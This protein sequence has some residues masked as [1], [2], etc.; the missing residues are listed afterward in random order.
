MLAVKQ[1]FA[2]C[3]KLK[4]MIKVLSVWLFSLGGTA[5]V[6][7]SSTTPPPTQPFESITWPATRATEPTK[8]VTLGDFRVEFESTKL[9]DIRQKA[10]RGAISH[11]GDAAGTVN[12]LCYTVR[13][14]AMSDR[15]WITSSE[16]GGPEGF[17]TGV[18][19]TR[20][21]TLIAVPSC[22]LLPEYLEPISI[23]VPVWLGA[24]A[25]DFDKALGPPSHVE[26]AWRWYNF[27]TK[28]AGDGHCPDGY[29][30]LNWLLTRSQEGRVIAIYA[31]QVTSC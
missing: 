23:D 24:N 9:E 2:A 29:D 4:P 16:M 30:Y 15:I 3:G 1:P 28:V 25:Q 11:Q 12:W 17:I 18:T 8:G 27:Q 13:H 19:A 22:P 20:T 5:A 7:P 14:G 10:S 6:A 21:T 31:G 26:G